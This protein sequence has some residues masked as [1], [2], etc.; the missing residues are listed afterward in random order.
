MRHRGS[1]TIRT[2]FESSVPKCATRSEYLWWKVIARAHPP[3]K[4]AGFCEDCTIEFKNKKINEGKC[5]NPDIIFVY[6]EHRNLVGR[7]P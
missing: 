7:L 1:R 6:D 2:R 5:E 3:S 4:N